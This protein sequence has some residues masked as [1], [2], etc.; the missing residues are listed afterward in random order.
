MSDLSNPI[1]HDETK[2]REWLEARLWPNGPIC[3]HCGAWA[4]PRLCRRLAS[5]W[6]LPVQRLP[7]AVHGDGG[8]ALRAQQGPA[9]TNGLPRRILMMASKKGMSALQMGRML[10]VSKKT[11]WFL[12][13]AIASHARNQVEP[14]GWR[15]QDR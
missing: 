4:K 2:A 6:P 9:A 1:F 11:A 3:P 7:R 10:G 13:H 14:L 5:S 15:R 8:H 12:C